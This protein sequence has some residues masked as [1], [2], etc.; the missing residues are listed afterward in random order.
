MNFIPIK[1]ECHSGYK[2]DE[3]PICFYW[4]H[5]KFEIREI[6]DRWYQADPTVEWPEADYFK[7][8]TAGD[9]KYILK[10]E[11]ISDRWFAVTPGNALIPFASN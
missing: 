2:S 5:I 1:V 11:L 10:H 7:V 8:I 9:S 3:Y 4:E 6:T